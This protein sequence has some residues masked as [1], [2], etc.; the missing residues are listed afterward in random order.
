[1][2]IDSGILQ[3]SDSIFSGG[4]MHTC[5]WATQFQATVY[6]SWL[7]ASFTFYMQA[8]DSTD[9]LIVVITIYVKTVFYL[10]QSSKL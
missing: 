1:M 10:I 6:D 4:T 9:T 7:Y 2:R 3:A 5:F 8:I